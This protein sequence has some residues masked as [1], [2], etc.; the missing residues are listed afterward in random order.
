LRFLFENGSRVGMRFIIGGEYSYI[1]TGIDVIPRYI[2]TN[3]Q[4][5]IF[6]MRL[7]DQNFLDKPYNNREVRPEPDEVYLHS[8]KQ[9]IKL[10]ITR[11][12]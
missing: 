1:G 6:G 12:Y 7:M 2:K 8:R 3:A 4:W 5:F 9:V 11:N 10:K